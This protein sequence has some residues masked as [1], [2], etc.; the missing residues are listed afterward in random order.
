MA[1]SADALFAKAQ[2]Y[3]EQMEEADSDDWR[4]ALWSAFALEL[5][6]RAALANVS[7]V[8]LAETG[9]KNWSHVF[10]ALGFSPLDAKY[11]PRSIP[12][13]EVLKRLSE[14]LEDFK[15]VSSF[16]VIHTGR[17]N[18]EVHSGDTP[19]DGIDT[20]GWHPQFY[21]ACRV[22]LESMDLTLKHFLNAAHAEAA[23]KVVAAAADEAAKAVLGDI[24]AH[25]KVWL[26]TGQ[27]DQTSARAFAAVWANKHDGHRV[28]CPAC[29][30]KALVFGD[31]IAA[32][33]K[34][35]NGDEITEVQEYLPNKFECV[36]CRLKIA[37]LSR[38]SAAKLGGRYKKTSVYDA[39]AYYSPD[40]EFQ[41]YEEDNNEPN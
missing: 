26:A 33:H 25:K 39:A 2:R 32:A 10:Y 1:F 19:Y 28:D 14:I 8:L 17:R 21:K 22:L 27:E 11:L 7:P 23:E 18:A 24:A 16:C 40:D 5:L 36:A 3:I 4:H 9:E 41:G 6:A 30:T 34:A 31:P 35:I 20:S 15:E 29:E 37:G 13:N 38:L 12:T